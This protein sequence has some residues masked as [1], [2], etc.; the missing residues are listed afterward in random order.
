MRFL[1]LDFACVVC[2][3]ATSSARYVEIIEVSIM[4]DLYYLNDDRVNRTTCM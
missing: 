3:I 4:L 2:S 1:R